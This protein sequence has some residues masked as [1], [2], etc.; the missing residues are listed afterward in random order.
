MEFSGGTP[1]STADTR[2][3]NRQADKQETNRQTDHKAENV[4]E[5]R[6]LDFDVRAGE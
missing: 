6:L 4:N 2:H 3:P 5:P 1:P